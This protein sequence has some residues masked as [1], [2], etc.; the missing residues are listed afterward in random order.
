MLKTVLSVALGLVGGG[1][2]YFFLSRIVSGVTGQGKIKAVY[3]VLFAMMPLAVL[4]PVGLIAP[5]KLLLAGS[6]T[7]GV[8]IVSAVV[9][10]VRNQT[11]K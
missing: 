6:C 10:S 4:L 7:V 3:L 9:Q 8:L 11:K 2:E 5:D 1:A